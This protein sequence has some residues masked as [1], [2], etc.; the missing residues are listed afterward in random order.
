MFRQDLSSTVA[1]E[2]F[3]YSNSHGDIV[4]IKDKSGNTLNEYSYNIWR[5]IS[6]SQ[7][8]MSN[9][10]KYSGEMYDSE[11]K[12]YYLRARYYDP[13]LGRFI[14]ED[15]V[16]GQVD[17]PHSLNLYTYGWNNPL[18]FNDPDGHFA[19]LIRIIIGVIVRVAAPVAVKQV[20][21][22][23]GK[24]AKTLAKN[25]SKRTDKGLETRGYKP[26]GDERTLEGYVKK[27][28]P[29]N[30]ETTLH[31][32]SK[33]FNNNSRNSNPDGQFKRFGTDS[34]GGLSP[35]YTSRSGMQRKTERCSVDKV[36]KHKVVE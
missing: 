30:K 23:G 16:K 32:K 7:E 27:S 34:H 12:F 17:N 13:S 4:A 26:Q 33:G 25:G 1:K 6:S 18:K 20:V 14:T 35:M 9:P 24:L 8:T 5:N 10:F 36:Q 19:I 3:Y 22:N 31:T 15:T 21:K 28:V 29:S 2:G 11:T